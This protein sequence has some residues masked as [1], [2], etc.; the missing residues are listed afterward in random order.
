M[1]KASVREWNKALSKI[2]L[3]GETD[4]KRIQFYTAMYHTMLMPSE[5]TGENP[6]W[7]SAEP[8]YDDY[9]TLWDTFRSS[10][11]LLT[12]IAPGRQRDLIRS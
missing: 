9:Y 2:Q 4:S 7:Q 11:P 5:R 8:Y 12:L 10:G 6:G 3:H 1:R